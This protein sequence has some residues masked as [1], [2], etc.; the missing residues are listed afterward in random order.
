[1]RH[2]QAATAVTERHAGGLVLENIG[3]KGT[4]REIKPEI[5]KLVVSE[6]QRVDEIPEREREFRGPGRRPWIP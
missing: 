6:A 2:G 5:E 1:M 3:I 4:I